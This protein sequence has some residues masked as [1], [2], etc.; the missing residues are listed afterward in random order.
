MELGSLI[1]DRWECAEKVKGVAFPNAVCLSSS[2]I[3]SL[4][5]SA[6]CRDFPDWFVG[7]SL[8][9]DRDLSVDGKRHYRQVRTSGSAIDI[10]KIR[11]KFTELRHYLKAPWQEIDVIWKKKIP[12]YW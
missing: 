5:I 6:I 3:G 10:E 7:L 2:H 11:Q 8:A 9:V 1:Y 4:R 12:A